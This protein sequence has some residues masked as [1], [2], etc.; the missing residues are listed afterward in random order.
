MVAAW[1][2]G[3][4]MEEGERSEG[5]Y[6]YRGR[7]RESKGWARHGL[8]RNQGGEGGGMAGHVG[9]AGSEGREKK[10]SVAV[11]GEGKKKRKRKERKR[12]KE[13][14][15]KKKTEIRFFELGGGPPPLFHCIYLKTRSVITS[16]VT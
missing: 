6:I 16:N 2:A 12:K 7:R 15:Y 5:V 14:K 4:G 8:S 11:G 9:I 10:K 3:V 1:A 13:K